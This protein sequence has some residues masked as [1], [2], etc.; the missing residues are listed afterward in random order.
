MLDGRRGLRPPSPLLLFLLLKMF[1][2]LLLTC[3]YSHTV[4]SQG[5]CEVSAVTPFLFKR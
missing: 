5:L 3:L 2:L 4:K 1:Y